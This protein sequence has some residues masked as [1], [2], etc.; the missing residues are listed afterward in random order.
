MNDEQPQAGEPEGEAA[1]SAVAETRTPEAWAREVFPP[2]ER[3]RQNPQAFLHGAAAALHH[4]KTHEHHEGAPLQLTR[5][6]YEA[7]IEAAKSTAF[8][9]HP[10]ALSPHAGRS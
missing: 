8:A 5:A 4:W 9:P 7:A 2:S 1:P 10:A 3:G 6:D